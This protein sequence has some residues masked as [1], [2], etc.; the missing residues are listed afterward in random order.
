LL[1][2][3]GIVNAGCLPVYEDIDRELLLLIEDLLW[4][5]D[6]EGTDK[7]LAYADRDDRQIRA[8]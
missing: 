8:Q 1:I 3:P 5:R 4:N 6:Q 7:L 2:H